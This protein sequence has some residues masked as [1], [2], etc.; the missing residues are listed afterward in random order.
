MLCVRRHMRGH[1]SEDGRWVRPTVIAHLSLR[2]L[3]A[4]PLVGF[5]VYPRKQLIQFSL[6][7]VHFRMLLQFFFPKCSAFWLPR[8]E[9]RQSLLALCCAVGL[10]GISSAI[11]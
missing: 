9:A 11:N 4:A 10:P 7:K 1:A 8:S 3:H 5:L 2:A 6:A